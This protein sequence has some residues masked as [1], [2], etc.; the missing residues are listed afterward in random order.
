MACPQ[1]ASEQPCPRPALYTLTHAPSVAPAAWRAGSPRNRWCWAQRCSWTQWAASAPSRARRAAAPSPTRSC[2][3]SAAVRAACRPRPQP[4]CSTPSRRCAGAPYANPMLS[5]HAGLQLW[6]AARGRRRPAVLHAA[7]PA[8]PATGLSRLAAVACRAPHGRPA[9]GLHA[10]VLP[11]PGARVGVLTPLTARL[12]HWRVYQQLE[13][14]ATNM[15]DARH[16]SP[17]YAHA[18]GKR[19]G[20]CDGPR[21]QA[22]AGSPRALAGRPEGQMSAAVKSRRTGC[23]VLVHQR[24]QGSCADPICGRR[25]RQLQYFFEAFPARDGLTT[26]MCARA[27]SQ[28]AARMRVCRWGCVPAERLTCRACRG[29]S[30]CSHAPLAVMPQP[31]LPQCAPKIRGWFLM[32]RPVHIQA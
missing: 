9:P 24:R 6:P 27:L 12:S 29:R 14:P 17:A 2:S 7:V 21:L 19:S 26:Y 15:P 22:L 11:C 23:M 28:R 13:V 20:A 5:G 3:W 31:R 25:E 18:G 4:T 16:R 30:C 10:A 8:H 1:A 32:P